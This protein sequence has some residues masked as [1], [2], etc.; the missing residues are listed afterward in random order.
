MSDELDPEFERRRKQRALV[1]AII[2]GAMALLF[3][4]VAMAKIAR[5]GSGA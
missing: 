1:T 3:F 2:L 4:F 5:E